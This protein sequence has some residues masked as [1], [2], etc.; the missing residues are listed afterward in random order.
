MSKDTLP[1]LL[2][3]KKW[4]LSRLG[5]E[6]NI[7]K[8][9][10]HSWTTGQ[11]SVD[12]VLVRK[13]AEALEVPVYNLLFGED[14]IDPNAENLNETLE[15]LFKDEELVVKIFKVVRHKAKDTK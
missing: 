1:K 11:R 3:K 7:S 2:K 14:A 8:S 13:V 4:S 12:P 10:L 9:I 15:P 6:C 5:R